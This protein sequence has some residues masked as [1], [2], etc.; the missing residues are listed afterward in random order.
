M[1]GAL[2]SPEKPITE[3]E[4]DPKTTV[5]E[6]LQTIRNLR[7]KGTVRPLKEEHDPPSALRGGTSAL[8]K[9]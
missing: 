7:E 9:H 8:I 2:P 1:D 4:I 5:P 6:L 3:A